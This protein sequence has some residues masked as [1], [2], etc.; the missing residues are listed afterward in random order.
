MVLF[1]IWWLNK[2][3]YFEMNFKVEKWFIFLRDTCWDAT[4]LQNKWMT[5]KIIKSSLFHIIFLYHTAIIVI[6]SL[7]IMRLGILNQL[8]VFPLHMYKHS[9]IDLNPLMLFRKRKSKIF[10]FF[11]SLISF[12]Q[13]VLKLSSSWCSTC[14][15][16]GDVFYNLFLSFLIKFF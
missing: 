9:H 7:S 6:F 10:F 11:I 3:K 15:E 2:R 12:S 8:I 5:A 14:V 1:S 4:K 16:S 13:M